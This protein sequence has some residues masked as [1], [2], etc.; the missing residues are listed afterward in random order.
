METNKTL[1]FY[2]SDTVL[3]SDSSYYK[4]IFKKTEKI[5]CAVFYICEHT[6]K[7]QGGAVAALSLIDAAKRALDAA[8]RTLSCRW[9]TASSELH[10]FLHALVALESNVRLAQ[11]VALM[12]EE[13]ADLLSL[14]IET[15]ARALR[16][17]LAYEK[18][19]APDFGSFNV[20]ETGGRAPWMTEAATRDHADSVRGRTAER[21]DRAASSAGSGTPGVAVGQSKGQ[22][23]ERRKALK[24]ILSYKR[25]STIKDISEKMS[26]TSEKTLQRELISMVEDGLVIKEGERRWSRYSL[27]PGA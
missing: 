18:V 22:R 3:L 8:L 11:S 20:A 14:E 10:A 15:V 23:E 2:K 26:D 12:Q 25:Q 13:V 27:A 6:D 4:Y 19:G 1:K 7:G 16:R 9:Y 21:G 5:A 24:D 17:Y